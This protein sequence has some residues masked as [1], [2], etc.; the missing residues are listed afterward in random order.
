MKKFGMGLILILALGL[1]ADV[2]CRSHPEGSGPKGSAS[3]PI[4]GSLDAPA[5]GSKLRETGIVG[6]WAVAGSGVKRIGIYID[7]Q[8]IR[9]EKTGGKRPDVGKIYGKDFPGAE[10]SGW[11]FILDVTKM[12]DGDHE[13]VAKVESNQGTVR[14]F[15]PIPFQVVH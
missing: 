5:P 9:F 15:G 4:L 1:G 2:G 11:T 12:A 13:M 10:L 6:G 8:L 3:E 7:R 14:E